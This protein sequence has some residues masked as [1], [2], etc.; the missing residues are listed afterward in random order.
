MIV[1][2][3]WRKKCNIIWILALSFFFLNIQISFFNIIIDVEKE[4]KKY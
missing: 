4:E 3:N 2:K 1:I